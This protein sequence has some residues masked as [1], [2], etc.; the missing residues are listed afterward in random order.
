[1]SKLAKA[2]GGVE[3]SPEMKAELKLALVQRM[4]ERAE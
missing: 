2:G 3:L 4:L 1:V